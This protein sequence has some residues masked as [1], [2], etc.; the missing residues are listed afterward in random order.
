MKKILSIFSCIGMLSC[1]SL[2]I[3]CDGNKHP[4]EEDK[5]PNRSHKVYKSGRSRAR[6]KP[7]DK[8]DT[9]PTSILSTNQTNASIVNSSSSKETPISSSHEKEKNVELVQPTNCFYVS[10]KSQEGEKWAYPLRTQCPPPPGFEHL[11]EVVYEDES[12]SKTPMQTCS[13]LIQPSFIELSDNSHTEEKPIITLSPYSDLLP[14]DQSREIQDF[15]VLN[16]FSSN[17]L[18]VNLQEIPSSLSIQ[19][20]VNTLS[21]LPRKKTARSL[22]HSY[23]AEINHF[24]DSYASRK[25]RLMIFRDFFQIFNKLAVIQDQNTFFGKFFREFLYLNRSFMANIEAITTRYLNNVE[26]KKAR[27]QKKILADYTVYLHCFYQIGFGLPP[28]FLRQW[29]SLILNKLSLL[30]NKDFFDLFFSHGKLNISLDPTFLGAWYTLSIDRVTRKPNFDPKFLINAIYTHGLL[31]FKPHPAWL[32]QVYQFFT[33]LPEEYE[34][35]NRIAARELIWAKH[36][37]AMN[38]LPCLAVAPSRNAIHQLMVDV[39]TISQFQENIRQRLQIVAEKSLKLYKPKVRLEEYL[40]KLGTKADG[41]I[42]AQTYTI[43]KGPV[44]QNIIVFEADGFSH[45]YGNQT[46]T[47]TLLRNRIYNYLGYILILV[48][49]YDWDKLQNNEEKD[50]YLREKYFEAMKQKNM[51]I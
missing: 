45:M 17:K 50:A 30:K 38:K 10:K 31:N 12:D 25:E 27:N 23:L 49:Y 18:A 41:V 39:P 3:A 36:F 51:G 5:K 1:A 35:D 32:T 19:E 9:L 11:Y 20:L 14:P 8:P 47:V 24:L 43:N 15:D 40:P 34:V 4:F 33:S 46:N 21:T 29:D 13:S 7:V 16:Y 26:G 48:P 22:F 2:S 37:L 42:Y 44:F 28:K 6:K